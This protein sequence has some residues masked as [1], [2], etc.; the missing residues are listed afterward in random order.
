[1][2]KHGDRKHMYKHK[3][4][5]QEVINSTFNFLDNVNVC[6]NVRRSAKMAN[7]MKKNICNLYF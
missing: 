1:M 3:G 7:A 4:K 6:N 2:E 5:D